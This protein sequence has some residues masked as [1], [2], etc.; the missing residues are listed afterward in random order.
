[1]SSRKEAIHREY[2]VKQ[3]KVKRE[4]AKLL[5]HEQQRISAE[6]KKNPK[7]FWQYINKKNKSNSMVGT[8]NG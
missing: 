5:Q 7:L 8:V 6:C 4:T 3:N 1:M 2:K